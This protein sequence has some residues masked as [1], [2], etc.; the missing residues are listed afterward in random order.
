MRGIIWRRLLVM[1]FVA[2]IAA[3]QTAAGQL[4]D[5]KA[6]FQRGDY[7]TA[8]RL[9]RPLADQGN[10]YA[11][12]TLG[13]IYANGLG[14]PQDY[15]EAVRW[16]RKAADQGNAD[17]Q[18]NLGARYAKQSYAEAVKWYRRAAEQGNA[19]AQYKLGVMYDYG[20][21]VPQDDAEA[22]KWYRKAA[23]Q[24]YAQAQ[25]NLNKLVANGHGSPQDKAAPAPPIQPPQTATASP[26]TVPKFL[27]GVPPAISV[28]SIPVTTSPVIDVVGRVSSPGRIIA[29]RVEGTDVP[30]KPDG[31]FAVRRGIPLGDSE[32][33]LAATDE[34]GQT[35]EAA[36]HMVRTIAAAAADT[37]PPLDPN[38]PKAKPRPRA[39]ALIVGVENYQNAPPAEFAE[40]DARTF[41]DYA[42][43]SLGVPASRIKLLTGPDARRLDVQKAIRTWLRPLVVR[44]QTD[45]F[46]FFSG[47]GLASEGGDDLFLLPYD[48]DRDLLAESAIRR[49]EL[50]VAVAESGAASTT[51][52]LDTCYS[53]G[54]RGRDSLIASAR[55]I[56]IVAKEEAVPPNVTILA[57]AG[58][59]QLSSSLTAAKHGLFSYFLMKGLEGDAAGADHTITA[60]KLEAYLAD[61]IPSE[62][63][64][65][66]RAQ[67]PQLIGDGS[68]VVSSW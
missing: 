16:F 23:D 46:V 19:L 12:N 47:H 41:Y 26:P 5:V 29:L 66:G 53:G 25:S 8:L 61:H 32:I 18:Y 39:I 58:N 44:G 20:G 31:S 10:A 59:D 60:A 55:P 13:V 42:I 36:I 43:N 67:T 68:R 2:I 50:I 6:A 35:G 51:L 49:K 33:K 40:N 27:P 64:K 14:V 56:M 7:A 38:H 48:G 9:D 4:D 15:A 22:V 21:G 45:V 11:Q 62:A 37:F 24:G 54:T 65:L 30:L 17:A 1:V 57:A 52:F 3:G 34:W 63:A 28:G